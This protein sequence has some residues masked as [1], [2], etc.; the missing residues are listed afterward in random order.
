M[1]LTQDEIN[2]IT[3][4]SIEGRRTSSAPAATGKDGSPI[5]TV[6]QFPSSEEVR[7]EIALGTGQ[8][9]LRGLT[10]G[11]GGMTGLRAGALAS[12][13][14]G[15]VGPFAP[16]VGFVGGVTAGSMLAENIDQLF[17]DVSRQD[18]LPY[19][20]GGKTFGEALAMSPFMFGIPALQ[21]GRISKFVTEIGTAARK[22][23]LRFLTAE[24]LSSTGAGIGAGTAEAVA[25]GSAG[26]RFTGEVAGSIFFPGKMFISVGGALYDFGKS[27]VSGQK[28][29]AKEAK[30]AE[31]LRRIIVDSGEDVGKL[32]KALEAQLPLGARPTSAQK[33]GSASLSV[34]ENTLAK[35]HPALA[36]A[37][38][39]QGGD[40][41]RAYE[42]TIENLRHLG[43]PEALR[44]AAKIRDNVLTDLLDTRMAAA[45]RTAAEKLSKIKTDRP[46]S[47][48]E[49][50]E[51]VNDEVVKALADARSYERYLWGEATRDTVRIRN[52]KGQEVINLRKVSPA[53]VGEQFLEV[54]T[55]M[56]PERFNTQMPTEIR[57]I[58]ARLGID[59]DT[60]QN[61]AKGQLTREYLDTGRVP[62]E[63]LTRPAGPRTT[64]RESIF[65]TTDVQDMIN[66]RSD[67]LDYARTAAKSDTAFANFYGRMAE[68]ALNDLQT[69]KSPAYDKARSFSKVLNDYFTRTFA[70]D[71]AEGAAVVNGQVVRT[72]SGQKI[73]PEIL[74]QRSY[75]A[76][77]DLTALRMKQVEEAVGMMRKQYDDAVTAFG[78]KSAQAQALKP[79]ADLASNRVVSVRDA[80]SRTLLALANKAIDPKTGRVDPRQL[81]G[82]VNENKIMLDR[83]GLTND[84]SDA[85][86]AENALRLVLDQNS[87]MNT[88]LR[89]QTAFAQ[90]LSKESPTRVIADTLNSSFPVKG[91][92][93]LVRLAKSGGSDAV[94]GLG[95]SIF[96]Y[97]YMKAGGDTNFSARAFEKAFFEP[98][99]QK[100]GNPSVYELLRNQKLMTISQ[101]KGLKQVLNRMNAVETAL[102]NNALSDD[103]LQGAGAVEELALRL[104]GS[105]LGKK[106]EPN[107]LIVASASSKFMR[108][109]FD[110][111]PL[112]AVRNIMERS[113]TDPVFLGQ[114]LKKTGK[115]DQEKAYVAARMFNSAMV[116]AGVNYAT[117]DQRPTIEPTLP[118]YAAPLPPM[119]A[120]RLMPPAPP[121]R[122]V[123]EQGAPV[124]RE[125]RSP[126]GPVPNIVPSPMAPQSNSR[127]MLQKLFPFDATLG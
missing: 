120:R 100:A 70:G 55:L 121:T 18:L 63:F 10:I 21:G 4:D 110:K 119:R 89:K 25:P 91:F 69:L 64:K 1:A 103:I 82:F 127:E 44:R 33:T 7:K 19:R 3:M 124:Q 54:A 17:P 31:T 85:T 34:I 125:P 106:I 107:S 92:S 52:V 116:N 5:E 45:E 58:M 86:K 36:A 88:T 83:L 113:M 9:F 114:L 30:V 94:E 118:P 117:S 66:I 72:T 37:I 87:A 90:V 38:K 84:L 24:A 77:N 53:N 14:L 81:Q 8:G 75:G 93:R 22:N 46:M 68:G 29:D 60:I 13:A 27:V 28:F 6:T 97:A 12:P 39:Q 15:P 35:N 112:L 104:M 95:A 11:A 32:V 16:A 47:R 62:Q 78:P 61:Y 76:G 51:M 96:D 108:D 102:N 126:G 57:A 43:T 109:M 122:G 40:T 67:L 98:V 2:Q 99:Q 49:A 20:A 111:T 48:L 123:P 42:L 59:T 74:V 56:T 50:G 71:V 101:A 105:K 115:L 79:Y 26:M 41:L 23:P 80:H 65:N 73:A